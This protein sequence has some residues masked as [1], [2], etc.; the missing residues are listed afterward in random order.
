MEEETYRIPPG[1]LFKSFVIVGGAY[2]ITAFNLLTLTG[3]LVINFFPE[4]AELLSQKDITPE[5]LFADPD[6]TLPTSL[7]LMLLV[8]HSMTCAFVGWLVSRISPFAKFNHAIFV[9]AIVFVSLLQTALKVPHELRLKL[10][11]MMGVFPIA[12]LIGAKFAGNSSTSTVEAE[13]E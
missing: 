6:T 3:L 9:A 8:F 13:Q 2:V 10:I 1:V 11:V 4:T 7:W 5:E 12:I